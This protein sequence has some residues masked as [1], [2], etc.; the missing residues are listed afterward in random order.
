MDT[1]KHWKA[2]GGFTTLPEPSTW[3]AKSVST[4]RSSKVSYSTTGSPKLLVSHR[5]PK[6]P[7]DIS[8]LKVNAATWAPSDLR[9]TPTEALIVWI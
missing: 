6:L 8:E 5:L 1:A 3:K 9:N 4:Q 7:C 2:P